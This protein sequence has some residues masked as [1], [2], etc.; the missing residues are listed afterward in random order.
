MGAR[1]SD[2]HAFAAPATWRVL[3]IGWI[4]GTAIQLQQADLWPWPFLAAAVAVLLPLGWGLAWRERRGRLGLLALCWRLVLAAALA[5]CCVGLRASVMLNARMPGAL[6][7]H[8][9]ELVGVVSA[10]P[11]QRLQLGGCC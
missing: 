4:G 3:L 5:W 2:V 9:L 7:G 6:E 8:D 11:L 10:M 1:A